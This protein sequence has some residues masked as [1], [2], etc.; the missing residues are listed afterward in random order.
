MLK[1]MREVEL[2]RS[3]QAMRDA[4]EAEE[5]RLREELE[6][7]EKALRDEAAKRVRGK[8]ALDRERQL[9][10]EKAFLE[11]EIKQIE[12]KKLVFIQESQI[13]HELASRH[14]Q[15]LETDSR[16]TSKMSA[17]PCNVSAE[18]SMQMKQASQFDYSNTRF[19]NAM[20][21]KH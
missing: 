18:I 15:S 4:Q 12:R 6:R 16:F 3:G 17:A 9:M 5:R 19:H 21:V 1:R 2:A 13:A 8:Q 7:K 14:R 11:E 10:Q 20:V